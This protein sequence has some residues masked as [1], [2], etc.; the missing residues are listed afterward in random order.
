[1]L[2]RSAIETY[3][4]QADR[5]AGLLRQY[6]PQSVIDATFQKYTVPPE[7]ASKSEFQKTL[8]ANTAPPSGN[9]IPTYDPITRKW[10]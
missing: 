4:R 9:Q 10:K 6:V 3:N 5:K 1:M 2:F 8:R 7:M